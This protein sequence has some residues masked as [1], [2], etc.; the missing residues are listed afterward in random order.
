MQRRLIESERV[1]NGR[2]RIIRIS[3]HQRFHRPFV[4]EP[5]L[6]LIDLV[7]VLVVRLDRGEP[8]A[9]AF[10]LGADR[11]T[12]FHRLKSVLQNRCCQR[13]NQ[14]IGTVADCDAPVS[15]G[16][17]R[18]GGSGFGKG[19][20]AVRIEER[21]HHR[22][23]AVELLLRL[24]RARRLEVH[25]PESLRPGRRGERACQKRCDER[26]Q[27][28]FHGVP[29]FEVAVSRNRRRAHGECSVRDRHKRTVGFIESAMPT[30]GISRCP[31]ASNG[32]IG[33]SRI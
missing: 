18:I 5:A 27:I 11:L 24:R 9:L 21:M 19:L 10:G 22:E 2:L 30:D 15:D 14:W 31:F 26:S 3:L 13:Q 8:V 23:A 4:G 32:D 28:W 29:S 17:L 16:A 33:M 25:A 12:L 20:D 1:E 6:R 7:V